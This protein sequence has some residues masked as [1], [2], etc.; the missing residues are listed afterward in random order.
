[1]ETRLERTDGGERIG[2][3]SLQLMDRQVE[4]GI[5][6]VSQALFLL[7]TKVS[8][9]VAGYD[10]I[11][12][13]I[14]TCLRSSLWT[15]HF[16]DQNSV[17][18]HCVQSPSK[19]QW[20]CAR[21]HGR[22]V[23]DHNHQDLRLMGLITLL[24]VSSEVSHARGKCLGILITSTEELLCFSCGRK[25]PDIVQ[26]WISRAEYLRILAIDNSCPEVQSLR[27]RLDVRSN[28]RW[29]GKNCETEHSLVIGL[30]LFAKALPRHEQGDG[31]KRKGSEE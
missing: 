7:I 23:S 30:A 20:T 1:M 4:H 15:R 6:V 12:V 29:G 28:A 14:L 25:L 26:A 13:R 5:I 21:C 19:P 10:A 17:S 16:S 8:V 11:L 27:T 18:R 3:G 22:H 2:D 31:F 24:N 9:S